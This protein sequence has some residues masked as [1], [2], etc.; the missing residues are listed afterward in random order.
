MGTDRVTV[1][2]LTIV[3]VDPEKRYLLVKGPVPGSNGALVYVRGAVKHPAKPL[4]VAAQA[5]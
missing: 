3:R 4:E 5:G 2:N 1:Q